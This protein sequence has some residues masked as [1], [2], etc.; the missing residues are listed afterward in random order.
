MRADA[1]NSND[2][3]KFSKFH[4]QFCTKNVIQYIRMY[5]KLIF[6]VYSLI[7]RRMTFDETIMEYQNIYE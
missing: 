4:Q 3:N 2:K 1:W 6:C 7:W 5:L